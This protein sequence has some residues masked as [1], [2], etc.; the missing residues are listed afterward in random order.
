M[1]KIKNCTERLIMEEQNKKNK[2]RSSRDDIIKRAKTKL[3][4]DGINGPCII[5]SKKQFIY[6]PYL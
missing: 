3:T 6:P 2:K 4:C 1:I 5:T